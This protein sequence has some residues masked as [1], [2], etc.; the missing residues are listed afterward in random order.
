MYSV[1]KLNNSHTEIVEEFCYEAGLAGY[2]NNASLE[3]M[4]FNGQYD[5]KNV[6][7]FWAVTKNE[8]IISV[9]G[10]HYWYDDLEEPSMMRCLFRSATLPHYDNVIT[11]L[12][13]YHM[14]SLPFS[15][16]LPLQINHGL[17]NG[18]KH[19]YITTSNSDHDASG[20]MKRTHKVLQLLERVDIVKFDNDEIVYST[21]QTKW[22]INLDTYLE[23]LRNFHPA[24]SNAGI[25]SDQEYL[26]IIHNG[27]SK[28]WEGF[29]IQPIDVL[30]IQTNHLYS[31]HSHQY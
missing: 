19:F 5:L 27:F 29:C 11:G 18:V 13:K 8:K 24:R 10:C 25:Q 30:D 9:S 26:D 15:V 12:N 1:I 14:N 20:K 23:A 31:K 22:E 28:P 3:V 21:P 17:K 7:S 4:K 2:A 6:P 16:M